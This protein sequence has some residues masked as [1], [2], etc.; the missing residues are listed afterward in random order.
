MAS[1][2]SAGTTSG[3]AIAIAGD[4]TGNLAFQ[5]SAGTYTQTMPNVTG[6]VMV[7]GNMPAFSAYLATTQTPTVNVI[8]KITLNTKEFDT[9]SAFDSTTNYRFTP[10]VAGYYQINT[11]V[12]GTAS[13]TS[14]TSIWTYIYKNGAIYRSTNINTTATITGGT[15]FSVVLYLNGSTDYIELYGQLR[16]STGG[17]FDGA[18]SGYGIQTA[19]SGSLVR[20][21]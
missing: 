8:T 16:N 1:T 15:T 21:A 2:I 5:T 3:T 11:Q 18:G 12:S 7:S 13:T 17:F 4:T 14:P 6:T 20:S 9:A 19:M 10:L